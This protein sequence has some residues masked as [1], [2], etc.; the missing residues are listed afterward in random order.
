MNFLARQHPLRHYSKVK[1]LSL[2]SVCLFLICL[3]A[4]WIQ[5]VRSQEADADTI[6]LLKWYFENVS[7]SDQ[8]LIHGTRYYDLYPAAP[9]NPFLEPDEFRTGSV[10]INTKEYKPVRLKYDICNQRVIMRYPLNIGGYSEIVLINDFIRGFEIEGRKFLICS[11]PKKGAR[12][13]QEIG[14]G[15]LRCLYFWHKELVPLNNSLES[16]NQYTQENKDSYLFM[17]GQVFPYQ[18]KRAFL[19]L[20]PVTLQHSIRAYMKENKVVLRHI[21]DAA[22]NN[23]LLFCNGLMEGKTVVLQD[24][25]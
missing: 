24:K 25:K 7:Q 22:M 2:Q 18:G 6:K 10:I 21:T 19:T 9:G 17:D 5:T 3:P 11:L 16:Y 4:L 20:F 8:H 12:Y 1:N 14:A 15:S 13:C 23:L